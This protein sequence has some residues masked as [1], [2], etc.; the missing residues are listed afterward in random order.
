MLFDV[1]R[2]PTESKDLAGEFP[3]VV[4]QLSE[5]LDPWRRVP[6]LGDD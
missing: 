3:E 4:K 5:R 2:D 1:R 6:V